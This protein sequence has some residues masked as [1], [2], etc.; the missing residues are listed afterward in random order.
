MVEIERVVQHV[1]WKDAS[2]TT[3]GSER[4]RREESDQSEENPEVGDES[5]RP[6]A[7]GEGFI[8]SVT[9]EMSRLQD[10]NRMGRKSRRGALGGC[11]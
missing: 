4:E 7:F 11:V 5:I 10:G 8:D 2:K 1:C 9:P 3:T 6:D